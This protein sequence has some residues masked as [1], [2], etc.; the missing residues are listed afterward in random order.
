MGRIPRGA[1]HLPVVRFRLI[2]AYGSAGRI[3]GCSG[4]VPDTLANVTPYEAASLWAQWVG[5][6]SAALAVFVAALFGYLTYANN[7]RSRDNQER[8]TLAAAMDGRSESRAGVLPTSSARGA[9]FV[10]RG[11]GAEK[12]LLVNEGPESALGVRLEGLTTLDRQRLQG[13]AEGPF[14]LGP[15]QAHEFVLVSRFTLS[16]PA[17]IVVFY[18]LQDGG[19]ELRRV[20]QVPAP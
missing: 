8:A 14:D 11:S 20:L 9:D 16:G 7:K 13:A 1:V 4:R 6:I 15:G 12:W 10:L 2:D 17:N 18:R 19:S 3:D 5:S